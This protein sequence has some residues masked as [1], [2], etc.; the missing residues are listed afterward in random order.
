MNFFRQTLPEI[1]KAFALFVKG[2]SKANEYIKISEAHWLLSWLMVIAGLFIYLFYLPNAFVNAIEKG[3]VPAKILY[4]SFKTANMAS[5]I[6]VLL[7]GYLLVVLFSEIFK[8]QGSIRRY[9]IV[10]NW[11]FAI[12]I[13]L[14]VPLSTHLASMN[15]N[16]PFVSILFA[17]FIFILFFAYR[18]LKITLGINMFKA[19]T[20][21]TVLLILELIMDNAIDRW[22]G[23]VVAAEI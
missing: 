19:F 10:Q 12:S 4:S 11:V 8:Y 13:I 23:L 3:A 20:L 1:F 5:L 2:E 15:E 9:I 7:T 14:L 21:L 17:I 16:S 6:L 18:T 22:F